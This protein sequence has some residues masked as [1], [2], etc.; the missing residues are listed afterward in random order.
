MS[1][2]TMLLNEGF[3][4]QMQLYSFKDLGDAGNWDG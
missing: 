2:H 1:E 3:H 4:S